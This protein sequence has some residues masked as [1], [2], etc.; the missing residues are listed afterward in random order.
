MS[1]LQGQ[2]TRLVVVQIFSITN[3]RPT[4]TRA[5]KSNDGGV[6]YICVT[7]F[8]VFLLD[9]RADRREATRGGCWGGGRRA[10]VL[11]GVAGDLHFAVDTRP[12]RRLT[13]AR[14]YIILARE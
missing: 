6:Q 11:A 9:L 8:S 4:P 3:K 14:F 2:A 10:R 13:P 7:S 12:A 5:V 1:A